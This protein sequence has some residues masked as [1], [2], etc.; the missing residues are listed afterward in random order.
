MLSMSTGSTAAC[1]EHAL[2]LCPPIRCWV[3]LIRAQHRMGGLG[4]YEAY[5]LDAQREDQLDY[6]FSYTANLEAEY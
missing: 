4:S 5:R 6:D 1:C 3:S 2:Q